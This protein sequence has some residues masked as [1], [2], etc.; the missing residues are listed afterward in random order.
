MSSKYSPESSYGYNTRI[1]H[2][3][4]ERLLQRHL[5][6]HGIK[7]SHWYF[8]R[9]LWEREGLTQREL[10]NETNL[11]E[12]STVIMLKQMEQSGLVRKKNDPDDKRKLRV[13]LT[14]KA[15]RLEK[16][17]LPIAIHLNEMAAAGISA[18]DLEIFI[19]VAGQMTENLLAP[20]DESS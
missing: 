3:A 14:P 9:I 15:R 12:S 7:N 5:A 6:E 2:R 17:L 20:E 11:R 19:R 10:S 16:R 8:L 18:D 4:F 1:L 13:F